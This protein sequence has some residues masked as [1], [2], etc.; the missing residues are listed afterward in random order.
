MKHRTKSNLRALERR[1]GPAALAVACVT[2]ILSV[3]GAADAARNAFI[4][5]VSTPAPGAVLK[6]NAKAQFPASAIPTVSHARL[7]DSLSGSTL[8]DLQMNCDAITVDMQT[9]CM[10]T[11]PYPVPPEDIGKNSF[12]YATQ[13]CADMGGWLPTAAQ[14][15]GA[16]PYVKLAS[17]ID[18]SALTA[19][20]DLDKTDGWKDRREMSATLVTTQS[21]S[22]AAGTIGVTTGSLGNPLTG[23]PDPVPRPRVPAPESLQYVTVFDNHDK[24]GFAGAKPVSQPENFRCAF[25]K[26]QGPP[27]GGG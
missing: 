8:P 22:N 13:K 27:R 11:N 9:F 21:G 20:V 23:E 5:A 16:A 15:I 26:F 12:F 17:T 19:S 2:L 10:M 6:L 24:G 4:N 7:A 18:D 3:T 25:N 1:S 14:L